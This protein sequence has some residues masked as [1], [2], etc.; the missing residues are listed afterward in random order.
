M[1]GECRLPS[2]AQLPVNRCNLPAKL[3]GS[4]SF[5]KHPTDLFIDGIHELHRQ[6]FD[7]LAREPEPSGR[8]HLFR[9]YMTVHF[10]LHHLEDAGLSEH[11][12]NTRVHADYLRTIRGWLFNSDGYEG[13][14]LKSWV[15]SRFGLTTRY[16]Q[17]PLQKGPLQKGPLQKG[18]LQNGLSE[19]SPIT[20]DPLK[21]SRT[22]NIEDRNV[23]FEQMR[24]KALYC[25]NALESQLDLL[26]SFCQFEL[27]K[28]HTTQER[29]TLFRGVNKIEE[30]D[31][32]QQLDK[33]RLIL[34]LNNMNSF[35]ANKER[36]DE[37]GDRCLEVSVPWQKVIYY[38]NLL[39]NLLQGEEEYLVVGGLY[40]VHIVS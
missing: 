18:P 40:Q 9:D 19:K 8:V 10:R 38:S 6:L 28:S 25:T 31:I 34:L 2:S 29:I 37:F 21:N 14:A 4:L 39:P 11:S 20:K 17:G 24:A 30:Y 13:A 26:Y 16:H 27:A 23:H 5:Q 33:H 15:E 22:D 36:A 35:S 3:L 12:K 32:L 7:R 1:I